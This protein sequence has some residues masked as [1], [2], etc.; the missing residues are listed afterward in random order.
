MGEISQRDGAIMTPEQ[1]SVIDAAKVY[2]QATQP[3]HGYYVLQRK[4][5]AM[6]AADRTLQSALDA[7]MKSEEPQSV[8]NGCAFHCGTCDANPQ[9][10]LL[11]R[12]DAVVS[13]ACSDHLENEI[14]YLQRLST[15]PTEIVVTPAAREP[16][17]TKRIAILEKETDVLIALNGDQRPESQGWKTN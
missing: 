3:Q 1:Q 7:L 14:Q 9:W 4:V 13:W 15:F 6:N 12:G 11:R 17:P 16:V 2:F 5:W 8:T 10:R